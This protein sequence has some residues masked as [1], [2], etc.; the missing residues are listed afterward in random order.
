[1]PVKIIKNREPIKRGKC[2]VVQKN[3]GNT[4]LTNKITGLPIKH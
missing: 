1:M 2:T 3:K 4:P